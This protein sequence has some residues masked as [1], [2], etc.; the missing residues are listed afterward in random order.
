MLALAAIENW[1]EQQDSRVQEHVAVTLL[2]HL[3]YGPEVIAAPGKSPIAQL[4]QW[5]NQA[6]TV[7]FRTGR[8]VSFRALVDFCFGAR[9]AGD[10]WSTVEELYSFIQSDLNAKEFTRELATTLLTSLPAL[11][12]EWIHAGAAWCDVTRGALSDVSL[13]VAI[14]IAEF[15]HQKLCQSPAAFNSA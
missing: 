1:L 5:L 15:E 3:G 6:G 14:S 9:F 8:I 7:Q 4:R 11:K 13:G 2:S 10:G 12:S